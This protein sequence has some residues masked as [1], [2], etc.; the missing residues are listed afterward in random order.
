VKDH[1]FALLLMLTAGLFALSALA[2]L[3]ASVKMLALAGIVADPASTFLARALGAALFALVP[4]V[5][6]MRHQRGNAAFRPVLASVVIYLLLS[7]VVDLHGWAGGVVSQAALPSA[8]VRLAL[9]GMIAWLG[10]SRT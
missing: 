2:Y 10:F 7:V 4:M 6:A 9:A 3:L 8:V 1:L 5:W